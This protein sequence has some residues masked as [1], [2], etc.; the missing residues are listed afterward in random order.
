MEKNNYLTS[1]IK[2]T[3]GTLL[4]N[5]MGIAI[6]SCFMTKISLNK[7]MFNV[8]YLIISFVSLAFGSII[9]ARKKKSKGLF[10]GLGVTIF[11]FVTVYLVCGIVNGNFTLNGFSLFKFVV[12]LIIGA[13]GGI[14]GV[15]LAR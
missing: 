12:S 7:Q 5:F 14:L 13:L 1:V 8:V 4:F 10:V 3:A 15:N 6:L 9:A 11:Y 2:G